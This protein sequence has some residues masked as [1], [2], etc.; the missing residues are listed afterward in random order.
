MLSVITHAALAL[1]VPLLLLYG[2]G[3]IVLAGLVF[4]LLAG[5]TVWS[6]FHLRR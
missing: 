6:V 4:L 2:G 5:S 1:S 3:G